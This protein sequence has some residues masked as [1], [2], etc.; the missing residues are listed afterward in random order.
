MADPNNFTEADA[1]QLAG[2]SKT[3]VS[4]KKAHSML[5]MLR[6]DL[7]RTGEHSKDLTDETLFSWKGYV[8]AHPERS[9][10]IGPGCARV[11]S[12]GRQLLNGF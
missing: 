9:N 5:K 1:T 12:G 4:R 2:C 11:C 3:R 6:E 7:E 8:A 10:F